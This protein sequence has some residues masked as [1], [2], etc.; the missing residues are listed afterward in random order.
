MIKLR[1][2]EL[3]IMGFILALSIPTLLLISGYIQSTA[4]PVIAENGFSAL[5]VL[6]TVYWCHLATEYFND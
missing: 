2:I 5:F 1:L 6:Q 3:I 4:E